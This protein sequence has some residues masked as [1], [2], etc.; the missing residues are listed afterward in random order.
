[1]RL[2]KSIAIAFCLTPLLSKAVDSIPHSPSITIIKNRDK[3][4]ESQA[5]QLRQIT[6]ALI[7]K[8]RELDDVTLLHKKEIKKGNY[9]NTKIRNLNTK[10][11]NLSK[12]VIYLKYQIDSISGITDTIRD[13]NIRLEKDSTELSNNLI[14]MQKKIHLDSLRRFQSNLIECQSISQ[15]V[16]CE[17]GRIENDF[18]VT[19]RKKIV[20]G[21]ISPFNVYQAERKDRRADGVSYKGIYY[22]PKRVGEPDKIVGE[23]IIYKNGFRVS[24]MID[25]LYKDQT[26]ENSNKTKYILNQ[27]NR[28]KKINLQLQRNDTISFG[29]IEKTKLAGISPD[30]VNYFWTTFSYG[31]FD[32][33]N[34]DNRFVSSSTIGQNKNAIVIDT[35]TVHS[36]DV[37]ILAW[38]YVQHDEDIISFYFNDDYLQPQYIRL[39]ENKP[40]EIP[41][42]LGD[43]YNKVFVVNNSNNESVA[44]VY[45]RI[46]DNIS[47]RVYDKQIYILPTKKSSEAFVIA[48]K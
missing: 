40:A 13:R 31:F 19:P 16:N 33:T 17:I 34:I 5:N 46:K 41:L 2:L 12:E 3:Q 10:I 8:Q 1:M 27:L 6:I 26:D 43:L 37:T 38:D 9:Q 48:Y 35:I 24:S 18:L 4:I 22:Q 44:D 21:N 23:L 32:I 15:I 7:K 14:G 42:R 29:F 11:S 25:T 36:K 30:I 45:I 20:E 28:Y 39:L 47:G